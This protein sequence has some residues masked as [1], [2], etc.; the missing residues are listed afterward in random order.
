MSSEPP[1]PP[2]RPAWLRDAER[3]DL[4][5]Y[6]AIARTPTPALDAAIEDEGMV[7]AEEAEGKRVFALR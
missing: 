2:R 4:G 6:A 7:R 3:L 1:P 5:V